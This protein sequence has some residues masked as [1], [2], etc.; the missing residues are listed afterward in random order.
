MRKEP[1]MTG[2]GMKASFGTWHVLAGPSTRARAKRIQESKQRLV[3]PI[4]RGE[5]DL[6]DKMH[7]E[8]E[9]KTV[10]ILQV[11]LEDDPSSND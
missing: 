8:Q 6:L 1:K 2:S 3:L 7:A 4:L 10:N 11:Y 9:A 5:V